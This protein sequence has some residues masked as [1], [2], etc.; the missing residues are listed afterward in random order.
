MAE[1]IAFRPRRPS[2]ERYP[3]FMKAID[4]ETFE[5]VDVEALSPRQREAFFEAPA[6][7]NPFGV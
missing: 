7:R 6:Q 3:T 2:A 1:I 4:G 5:C